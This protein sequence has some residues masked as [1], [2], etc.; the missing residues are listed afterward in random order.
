[1]SSHRHHQADPMEGLWLGLF[2]SAFVWAAVIL[3]AFG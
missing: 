2:A 1:M 3:I